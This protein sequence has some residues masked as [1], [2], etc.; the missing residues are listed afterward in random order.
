VK[1]SF[2]YFESG[3]TLINIFPPAS[4]PETFAAG[5]LP[6]KAFCFVTQVEGE[7]RRVIRTEA[8]DQSSK[9]AEPGLEG[10]HPPET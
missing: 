4:L 3:L 5:Q 2:H 9:V 10:I 6:S 8:K 7:Q 1:L